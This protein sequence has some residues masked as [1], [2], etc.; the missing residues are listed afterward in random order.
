MK[1]WMFLYS[2]I[3]FEV[4]GT[5]SM[6]FSEGFTRLIPSILIFVFY[7][8]SFV[9]LTLSLKT[10]N[11]SLA[12]AIWAG[13]GTALIAVIGIFAFHEPINVLKVIF[14]LMIIAGV[15]GLKINSGH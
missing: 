15:I 1:G 8:I 2:A 11:L 10:L 4:M 6:K 3:V 9:L 5:T 7:G 13:L 14:L 12:Y